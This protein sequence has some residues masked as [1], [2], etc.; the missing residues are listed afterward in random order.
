VLKIFK[1]KKEKASSKGQKDKKQEDIG[2][3]DRE[4][5]IKRRGIIRDE[6]FST[7][8]TKQIQSFV[9][10][11]MMEDSNL[12]SVHNLN[13]FLLRYPEFLPESEEFEFPEN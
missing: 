9:E 7:P 13:K 10:K 11:T 3:Q 1:R 8:Y 5:S 6:N 12:D 2:P 4:A